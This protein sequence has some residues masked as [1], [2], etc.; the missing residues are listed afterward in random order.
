M[1]TTPQSEIIAETGQQPEQPAKVEKTAA[2]TR[3]KLSEGFR[4]S[5]ITFSSL[6]NGL[7]NCMQ[8]LNRPELDVSDL[9]RV[10][11]NLATYLTYTSP[12]Q[13]NV[14]WEKIDDFYTRLQKLI[15]EAMLDYSV[16]GT[17]ERKTALEKFAKG[18]RS[19]VTNFKNI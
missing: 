18:I 15:R 17:P 19:K 10:T 12:E 14:T 5:G 3:D 9:E 2:D 1:E 16:S 4:E 11:A 13:V 8:K 7:E 6:L